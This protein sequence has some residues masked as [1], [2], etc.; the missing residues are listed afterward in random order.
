M[1]SKELAEDEEPAAGEE[2]KNNRKGKN[3][4]ENVET[5]TIYLNAGTNFTP[6][7]IEQ[8]LALNEESG[9]VKIKSIFGSLRSDTIPLISARPDFRLADTDLKT[10]E[11]EVARAKA[12]G[13]EVE[14]AAN[15]LLTQS[16]EEFCAQEGE[17][18]Q[19]LRYLQSVG[20]D[21]LILANPLWMELVSQH[22]DLNI[23]VSTILA[24]NNPLAVR[25]YAQYRVRSICADIYVNRNIPLLRAMQREGEKYGIEIELLANEVCLYGDVPCSTQLRTNCYLHS[26]FGGN[27]KLLYDGWPFSRCQ[28]ARQENP[29]CWLKIPYILPQHLSRYR[30]LTGISRFKISGRTNTQEYLFTCLRQY[31]QERFS[32]NI[33]KLF[34]LPQNIQ[35]DC[36]LDITAEKLE[37]AGYFLKWL[38]EGGCCDYQCYK[39]GHCE[40][41]YEE[42]Q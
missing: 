5:G 28:R 34:M 21:T 17:F 22:T 6:V 24:V 30:E 42:I 36:S 26:S 3:E 25:H 15:A 41:V 40:R 38:E 2:E 37:E 9:R 1:K 7:Q 13:I 29:I 39:C 20:V 16:V 8:F 33:Q 19:Q 4:R 18:L 27:E 35:S 14:Y 32:G 11:R 10:F 23:K 31:M 12:G